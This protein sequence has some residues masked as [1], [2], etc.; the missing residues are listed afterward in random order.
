MVLTPLKMHKEKGNENPKKYL[1]DTLCFCNFMAK[2]AW[3]ISQSFGC[4]QVYFYSAYDNGRFNIH[5]YFVFVIGYVNG[6]FF[7]SFK[8]GSFNEFGSKL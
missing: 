7:T 2:K 8:N 3:L 5:R 6:H 4:K 1:S